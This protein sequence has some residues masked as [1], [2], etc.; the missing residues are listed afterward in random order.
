MHP[1]HKVHPEKVCIKEIVL[2]SVFSAEKPS[3]LKAARPRLQAASKQ[4]VQTL[5]AT[6]SPINKS[7]SHRFVF[8]FIL[9]LFRVSA[10]SSWF[11]E[12]WSSGNFYY[13]VELP[14]FFCGVRAVVNT[15]PAAFLLTV[16]VLLFSIVDGE[17]TG[18]WIFYSGLN[19]FSLSFYSN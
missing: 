3:R 2:E 8:G 18:F 1:W 12:A 6:T 17:L 9:P 4:E 11:P 7:V 15:T 19:W 13:T 14:P 16:G 5:S 10:Q